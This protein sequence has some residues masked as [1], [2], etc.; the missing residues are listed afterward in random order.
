MWYRFLLRLQQKCALYLKR[1]VQADRF[2]PSSKR[3]SS[4]GYVRTELKLSERIYVCDECG[5][6]LDRDHNAAINLEQLIT[7]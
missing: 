3:C 5:N 1:F 6:T 2:Y 7:A 4:C